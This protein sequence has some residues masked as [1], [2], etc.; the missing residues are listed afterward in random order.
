[1]SPPTDLVVECTATTRAADILAW[2]TAF[3]NGTAVDNCAD[4]VTLTFTAGAI[5]EQCG[6]TFTQQYTFVAADDC[7]NSVTTFAN[8][9][10]VD[11]TAPILTLPT[12][13]T[14]AEC[15]DMT[16]TNLKTWL[17]S[18]MATD[19]CGGDVTITHAF[20]FES[21]QCNGDDTEIT[22]VYTFVAT[23]ECGNVSTGISTFVI[24]DSTDPV[25]TAPANLEVACGDDI[26]AAI[27]DWLDDY[28]VV[29]ECQDYFVTND[30]DGTIPSLCGGTE[31]VTWTVTDGC[32]ATTSS[33]A[34]IIVEAPIAED[35]N[36]TTVTQTAGLP[37]GS[38]FPLGTTRS[39][40]RYT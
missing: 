30:F 4:P 19:E 9:I 32:G 22:Q 27:I 5:T 1:M 10:I 8:L 17:D 21:E 39:R 16:T 31:T 7:G 26:N 37:S 28:T 40:H 6:M 2:E 38:T 11:E 25:I 24:I 23:D 33:T 29:E 15:N 34:D 36:G 3:G 18:A 12:P 14:S 20:N 35:C 13:E